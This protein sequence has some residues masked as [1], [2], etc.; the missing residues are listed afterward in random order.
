MKTVYAAKFH[1][2]WFQERRCIFCDREQLIGEKPLVS[3]CRIE[4]APTDEPKPF[5][6][7]CPTVCG[8]CMVGQ[9]RFRDLDSQLTDA[10]KRADD[11]TNEHKVT[12]KFLRETEFTI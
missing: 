1:D 8:G 7:V 4:W 3:I 9:R 5:G 11:F 12:Q 10:K 2:C 6:Y